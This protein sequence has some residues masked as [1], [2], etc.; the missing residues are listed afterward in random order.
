MI[1]RAPTR[2]PW[3][4]SSRPSCLGPAPVAVDDDADVPRD[5]GAA[6]DESAGEPALVGAV[7]DVAQPHADRLPPRRP[8][9]RS[10]PNRAGARSR[11]TRS[12]SSSRAVTKDASSST[13]LELGLPPGGPGRRPQA[14]TGATTGRQQPSRRGPSASPDQRGG[15]LPARG[16]GAA[17]AVGARRSVRVRPASRAGPEQLGPVARAGGQPLGERLEQEPVAALADVPRH[18]R[19]RGASASYGTPAPVQDR[20]GLHDEAAAVEAAELGQVR[21]ARG[22][23]PAA[24]A[25]R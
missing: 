17:S 11:R 15:T 21:P 24:G 25:P 6:A 22:A 20:L 2:W 8:C 16:P 19:P 7:G 1:L 12:T 10:E 14:S 13:G 23:A 5:G 9:S 3:F 4:G 18:R